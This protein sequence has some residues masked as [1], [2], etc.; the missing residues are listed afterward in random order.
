MEYLGP[1]DSSSLPVRLRWKLCR[2]VLHHLLL[3]RCRRKDLFLVFLY[4]TQTKSFVSPNFFFFFPPSPSSRP[5]TV[6][7]TRTS[8]LGDVISNNPHHNHR[9]GAPGLP[10]PQAVS[11]QAGWQG[12]GDPLLLE[13]ASFGTDGSCEGNHCSH[14]LGLRSARVLLN[15]APFLFLSGGEGGNCLLK[16]M[17][18]AP[19]MCAVL[20]SN[21]LGTITIIVASK[22]FK[23][24]GKTTHLCCM[25]IL[26]VH[27]AQAHQ[28]WCFSTKYN[29]QYSMAAQ[30]CKS[31]NLMLRDLDHSCKFKE[32]N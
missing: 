32:C 26:I 19:L 23:R 30:C 5:Q 11:V 22:S 13:N 17:P 12:H 20:C 9:G 31:A 6:A 15:P 2:A 3:L 24:R 1:V 29:E 28:V 18:C 25:C 14:V 4:W 21:S 16:V 10:P 7:R 27:I 8:D